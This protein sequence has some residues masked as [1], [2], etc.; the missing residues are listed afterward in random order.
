VRDGVQSNGACDCTAPHPDTS[1][2]C[3][4]RQDND[5]DA[6]DGQFGYRPSEPAHGRPP[7]RLDAREQWPSR[8]QIRVGEPAKE[9][10]QVPIRVP[11][12]ARVSPADAPQCPRSLRLSGL[13]GG[14][15][16]AGNPLN[17]STLSCMAGYA[18]W[19]AFASLVE[20]FA[21]R[22]NVASGPSGQDVTGGA[23][24]AS[25]ASRRGHGPAGVGLA[26]T[27]VN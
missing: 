8:L 26:V 25:E 7:G 3:G 19:A 17:V 21:S 27:R 18:A 16:L 9:P 6:A 13:L 20:E 10:R 23:A 1:E 2:E 14:V 4:E 11:T 15:C 24:A 22:V 12:I 5:D